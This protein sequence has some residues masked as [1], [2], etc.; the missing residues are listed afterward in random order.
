MTESIDLG[1]GHTLRF[2]AWAPDRDLNPQYEGL[3][4][5]ERAGAII[6]H[7]APDG[8]TCSGAVTFDSPTMRALYPEGP[9]WTVEQ[10]E[11]LTLSPSVLCSCGDHGFVRDGKWVAA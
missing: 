11:P 3:A 8:S 2:F 9:L 1:S 5:V 10:D 4:D 6:D 7:P